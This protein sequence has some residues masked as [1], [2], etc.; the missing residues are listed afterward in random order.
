M[1]NAQSQA[2][3]PDTESEAEPEYRETSAQT[4]SAC[5]KCRFNFKLLCV[6]FADWCKGKPKPKYKDAYVQATKSMDGGWT[7]TPPPPKRT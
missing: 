5:G 4:D 2:M 1:K 7:Q 6:C 3:M